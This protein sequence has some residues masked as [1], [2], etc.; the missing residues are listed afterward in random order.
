MSILT[1]LFYK[2]RAAVLAMEPELAGNTSEVVTR[3]GYNTLAEKIGIAARE[4]GQS[5]L[6]RYLAENSI[7]VYSQ[8]AVERY[9]D[10]KG[11]WAWFPLRKA[12]MPPTAGNIWV[13]KRKTP[14]NYASLYG[15]SKATQYQEAVPYPVLL[16]VESIVE[17]FGKDALFL[18]AALDEHPDPFLA[19][20]LHSEFG[21]MFIIERWDEPGFRDK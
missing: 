18:I 3:E 10:K 5:T 1:N 6:A 7:P 20:M 16:T 21:R 15:A 4:R 9:M 17:K 11:Y 8:E 13:L 12:D 14:T 19:C 2:P